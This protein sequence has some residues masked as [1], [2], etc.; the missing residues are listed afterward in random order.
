MMGAG[1]EAPPVPHAR[2]T[3]CAITAS[4]GCIVEQ[5]DLGVCELIMHTGT[6]ASKHDAHAAT[7]G[8]ANRIWPKA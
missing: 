1:G 3:I 8:C 4:L 5:N 7:Q 6:Q 2:H